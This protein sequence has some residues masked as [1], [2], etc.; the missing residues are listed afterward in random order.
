M[1]NYNNKSR[2]S[3]NLAISVH[4]YKKVYETKVMNNLMHSML[5]LALYHAMSL[6]ENIYKK[7][8]FL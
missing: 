3:I 8:T 2:L 6:V 7:Y 1:I 5:D 4:Q